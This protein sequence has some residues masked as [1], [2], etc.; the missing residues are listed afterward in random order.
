MSD[1]DKILKGKALKIYLLL[2]KRGTPMRVREI[3][4]ELKLSTPSL[5]S[6]HLS[7]L[8]ELGVVSK[9]ENDL[10]YASNLVK[11]TY[12]VDFIKVKGLIFPRFLFYSIFSTA[13]LFTLLIVF[14]PSSI[15]P[16]FIFAVIIMALTTIFMWSETYRFWRRYFES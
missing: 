1:L 3:Q 11:S 9:T 4:R 14:M 5:V 6:Y 12:L 16:S 7:K 10:Y 13:G 15:T 8:Y 2:L